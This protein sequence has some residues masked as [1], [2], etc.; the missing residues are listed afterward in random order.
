MSTEVA[1]GIL[2]F[3]IFG[4][5]VYVFNFKRVNGRFPSIRNPFV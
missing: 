4:V 3:E 5:L 2:A 1:A